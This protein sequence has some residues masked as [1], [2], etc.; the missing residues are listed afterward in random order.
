[1]AWISSDA[2][3]KHQVIGWPGLALMPLLN[4]MQV[5][6]RMLANVNGS[7]YVNHWTSQLAQS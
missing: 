7:P 3:S 6:G 1:M 4:T 5:I 2:S